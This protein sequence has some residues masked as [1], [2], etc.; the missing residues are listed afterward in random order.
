MPNFFHEEY[1][2][3]R[4]CKCIL[5]EWLGLREPN[6]GD[7]SLRGRESK[8]IGIEFSSNRYWLITMVIT[9]PGVCE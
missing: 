6:H 3:I 5:E 2:H 9:I 4:G 7:D 1:I 8:G